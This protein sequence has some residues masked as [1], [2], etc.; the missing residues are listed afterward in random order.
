MLTD[1]PGRDEEWK[2]QT[3]ANTSEAQFEQEYGNSFLGTGNTLISSDALLGMR[4]VDPNWRKEG[5]SVY[6]RPKKGHNYVA[7]VDVS[8]GRG[9]D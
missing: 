6:E 7:T 3:I 2:K 8:Q 9:F 1:V 5:V 4:A